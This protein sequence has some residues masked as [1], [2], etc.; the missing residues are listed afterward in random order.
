M[1]SLSRSPTFWHLNFAEKNQ[2]ARAPP[3]QYL[4]Q[5]PRRGKITS[6]G[7]VNY[8]SIY[9]RRL[10]VLP[11][12]FDGALSHVSRL[13]TMPWRETLWLGFWMEEAQ[14]SKRNSL[15]MLGTKYIRRSVGKMAFLLK[16]KVLCFNANPFLSSGWFRFGLR[17]RALAS[18]FNDRLPHI[19]AWILASNFKSEWS[20]ENGPAIS[21]D[22]HSY[23]A[24]SAF[25]GH[26]G[27]GYNNITI[28]ETSWG[29]I[30]SKSTS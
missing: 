5:A 20:Y 26:A 29:C 9:S 3:G 19:S 30:A 16:M 4:S 12:D 24:C 7:K 28:T 1:N 6:E 22:T 17:F 11:G 25:L 10:R 23:L 27:T 15:F 21:A 13:R 14:Q 8:Q 18:C 2:I